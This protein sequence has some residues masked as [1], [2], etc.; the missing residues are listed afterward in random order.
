MEFNNFRF[1]V[2]W[3]V[4]ALLANVF[5]LVWGYLRTDWQVTLLVSAAVL[6]LQSSELVH[7]LETCNRQFADFLDAISARDFSLSHQQIAHKGKSFEALGK[8]FNRI[9]QA[10]R[11]LNSERAV[12]HQL[13]E[14]TLEHI[15]IALLCIDASGKII[16]MNQAAK[17]LFDVPSIH[18]AFTLAKVDAQLPALVRDAMAGE[19]QLVSLTC[20]GQAQPLSMFT[21]K[22]ELLGDTYSLVSLQN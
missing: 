16:L 4:L 8:A 14:A 7:Y 11:R 12:Q 13:L 18:H 3:R 22:F 20:G 10:M 15:S 19:S 21:T 6:V 2:A 1:N 17:R 9:T 5:A